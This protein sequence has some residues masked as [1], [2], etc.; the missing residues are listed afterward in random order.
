MKQSRFVDDT[1]YRV[2]QYAN[3]VSLMCDMAVTENGV[4]IIRP[5]KY[6]GCT[7]FVGFNYVRS[8]RHKAG[9]GV[10][11]YL[12]DYQFERVWKRLEVNTLN[13]IGFS[14]VMTPE[15]SM[16]ADWKKPVQKWNHFRKQVCGSYF[17]SYGL[18]VYPSINWSDD[19]SFNWCFEG[20]PEG[21][22]VCVSAMGT[23]RHE[24]SRKA[25]LKGY[26]AMLER[27]RPETI[28]F[29]GKVPKECRGNI[30]RIEPFYTRLR[31]VGKQNEDE[32][33]GGV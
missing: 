17:Q 32:H 16:Y 4:P 29:Y 8:L 21:A 25:F 14:A 3:N 23:F 9:R 22:T 1:P 30:I 2:K 5:E 18:T 31:V 26:D 28:L 24:E 27:L 6:N 20:E 33:G 10:H 11:F 13:L 15:F 7:D 12:D 19:E